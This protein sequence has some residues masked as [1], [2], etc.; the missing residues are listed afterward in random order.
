MP[1][2][3]ER[4]IDLYDAWGRPGIAAEYRARRLEWESR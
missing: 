4:L 1:Y 2:L 3:I